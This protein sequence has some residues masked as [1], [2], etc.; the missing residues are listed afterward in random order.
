MTYITHNH[1]PPLLA[2]ISRVVEA[3]ITPNGLRSSE[4]VI[5]LHP[6]AP[7][8]ELKARAEAEKKA[9]D[10]FGRRRHALRMRGG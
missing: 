5:E 7:A 1:R 9:Q 3:L 10:E 6:M 4:P 2:A 8:A